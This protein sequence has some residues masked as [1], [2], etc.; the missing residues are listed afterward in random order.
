MSLGVVKTHIIDT[1]RN[2]MS[3]TLETALIK[4]CDTIELHH[5]HD[6]HGVDRRTTVLS[7]KDTAGN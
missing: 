3:P 6:Y 1:L 2:I 5:M 4:L 7:L